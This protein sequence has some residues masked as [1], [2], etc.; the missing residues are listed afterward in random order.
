MKTGTKAWSISAQVV[1]L[2]PPRMDSGRETLGFSVQAQIGWFIL[3]LKLSYSILAGRGE[4][5]TK[6]FIGPS[7]N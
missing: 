2:L 4:N 6:T 5:K 1:L 7:P 3:Q